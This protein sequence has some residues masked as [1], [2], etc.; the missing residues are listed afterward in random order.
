MGRLGRQGGTD[1]GDV[2]GRGGRA[3]LHGGGDRARAPGGVDRRPGL[4]AEPADHWHDADGGPGTRRRACADAD[5]R[6]SGR[7]A[8]PRHPE[9]LRGRRHAVGHDPDRR[10]EHQQ[11]LPGQGRRP[12]C[13]EA[14]PA[15]RDRWP[16]PVHVVGPLPG[17][18]RPRQGAERAEPLRMGGR[19]RPVRP[20]VDPGQAHGARAVRARGRHRDPRQGRPPGGLHGRR[21]AVRVPLQVRGK[22]PLRSREP[23]RRHGPPGRGCS[24][25]GEVPRR[26]HRR[27][28]A[29]GPG[30]GTADG[31]QR[32]PLAGRGGHQR[33]RGG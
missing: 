29:A 14:P 4:R 30:P 19:D 3:R 22:E 8:D 32:V 16:R 20:V 27:V 1:P 15:V 5:Q 6:R 17:P 28:A 25:R 11:L 31:G 24:L 13:R 33:A 12:E 21:R 7:R 23:G 18:V 10:G 26:R 9:Q 2:R